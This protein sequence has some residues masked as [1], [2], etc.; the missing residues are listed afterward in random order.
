MSRPKLRLEQFS[1]ASLA[2]ASGVEP[3]TISRLLAGRRQPL[4]PTLQKLKAGI[5]KLTRRSYSLEEI[6]EAIG[7]RVA[8]TGSS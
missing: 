5:L 1:Q 8:P 4:L 6:A 3:S 2:K 7:E